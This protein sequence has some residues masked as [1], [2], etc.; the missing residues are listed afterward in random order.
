MSTV[1]VVESEPWLGDHY[2]RVLEADGFGVVRA[3]HA[4]SAMDAID[5]ALPDAVVMS[6]S[7]SGSSS[8]A[9]L[10]ELQTYI[11]T[12]RIPVV[13]CSSMQDLTMDELEPYGIRRLINA[14]TMQ[15]SDLPMAIRSITA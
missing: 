7:L 14:R 5:D 4:Y 6:L 8:L 9:L 13:V 12:A 11:D 1:L 15:P 2:Q 10:H 3:A